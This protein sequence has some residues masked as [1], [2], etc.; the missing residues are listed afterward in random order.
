VI[1]PR[2]H[3]ATLAAH[4]GAL[5]RRHGDA[6]AAAQWS[7]VETQERRM[8]VLAE[9]GDLTRAKVLDFG[10]GTGHL[11]ALLR[12]RLGFCGEYVGWDL[13][14]EAL[15]VARAK[16]PGV[17]FE[18]HDVLAE[19][20]AER[21]DFAL[22]SGVFNNRLPDGWGVLT[23]ILRALWPACDRGLAFNA[24]STYVDYFDRNLAYVD[25]ERVFRFCKEELSPA[26]VLRHD[27]ALRDGDAPFELTVYVRRVP[28]PC[29][30]RREP[31]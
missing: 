29:R 9:I 14:E 21:F 4:Y 11:L 12:E 16:F 10:C 31:P 28:Q 8:A 25:P 26:V 1:D 15:A 20:I 19:G 6:P 13:C 3:L 5:V 18:R 27:Y 2:A 23:G 7:S 30:A 24:L 22:L 17:R